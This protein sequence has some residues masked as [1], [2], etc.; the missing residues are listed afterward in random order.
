MRCKG[1]MAVLV[2]GLAF[3]TAGCQKLNYSET[4]E[5]EMGD[6]WSKGFSA[7]AYDQNLRLT[8]EPESCAVSAYVV[9]DSRFEEF[10]KEVDGMSLD[11]EPKKDLYIAGQTFKRND[12]KQNILIE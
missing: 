9:A 4:A 11:K 2:A 6:A 1:L 7:P 12:S 3:A 10:R 5:V 8:V